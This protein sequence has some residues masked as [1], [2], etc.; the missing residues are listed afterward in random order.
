VICT[1]HAG[2]FQYPPSGYVIVRPLARIRLGALASF[3]QKALIGV[4]FG[5]FLRATFFAVRCFRASIAMIFSITVIAFLRSATPPLPRQRVM[6]FV[7]LPSRY[8]ASA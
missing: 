5:A 6:Y 1:G 3:E 7:A 2:L 4:H 8:G